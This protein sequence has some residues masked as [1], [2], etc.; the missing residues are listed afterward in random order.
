[1]KNYPRNYCAL[2]EHGCYVSEGFKKELE[3]AW[4]VTVLNS[5]ETNL[6]WLLVNHIQTKLKLQQNYF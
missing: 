2:F 4:L 1:M 3:N 5:K 6:F